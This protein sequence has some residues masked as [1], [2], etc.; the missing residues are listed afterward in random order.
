MTINTF[1]GHR[2]LVAPAAEEGALAAGGSA[3]HAPNI[4]VRGDEVRLG[5]GARQ[6]MH[7]CMWADRGVL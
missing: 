4:R 3:T 5:A 7:A 2:L 6:G 1:L